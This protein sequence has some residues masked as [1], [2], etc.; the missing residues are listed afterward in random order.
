MGLGVID[1]EMIVNV[2]GA[3][4]QIEPVQRTLAALAVEHRVDII[5]YQRPAERHAV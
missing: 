1:N 4:G 3:V 2:P 5:P